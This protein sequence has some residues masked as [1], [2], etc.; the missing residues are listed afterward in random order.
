[1]T[2]LILHHY[3]SS[4]FA[5]LIRTALGVKGLEWRSVIIP[6]MM[7]KPDLVALTGGYGRT[8]V[9]Q[10]DSEIYCDTA[11][12]ID[13]LQSLKPEPTLYPAPLGPLHRIIA[14][15]AGAGQFAAHVGAA[16]RNLPEGAL[17]PGFAD[18]RRRRFVGFDFDTM[19]LVAPHFET[20]ALTSAGWIESTLTDRRRY[21]GGEVIGHGDLALYANL[22]FLRAMPF[23][24]D[25]ADQVFALPRLAEWFERIA[26]I[27]H[28]SMIAST[29]DE[30]IEIARSTQP[31]AMDGATCDGFSRGAS[32]AIRT[33]Q[34]GDEPVEGVL[35]RCGSEGIT[36][37]R[38]SNRGGPV[39]VHF[40]RLGQ[41]VE[42]R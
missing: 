40:P 14:G 33:E 27:G 28:G 25:F 23:A 35:L 3:E 13:V 19:P 6:N 7:P 4:P 31:R 21:V 36:V 12:I 1:M 22:W 38:Q 32:V 29:P 39:N 20:Q 9:L 18:D 15:W 37:R 11:A 34:S 24:K 10:I 26:A 5:E 42:P 8:P 16:M 2:T 41:I 17:A 30:A